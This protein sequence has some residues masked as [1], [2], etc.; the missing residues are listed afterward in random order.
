ME[1]GRNTPNKP[2][3]PKAQSQQDVL[4]VLI[5]FSISLKGKEAT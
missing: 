4:L 1:V 2:K 5:L 3:Q